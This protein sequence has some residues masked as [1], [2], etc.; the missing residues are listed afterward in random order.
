MLEREEFLAISEV[1]FSIDCGG[2]PAR[3]AELGN[4]G[5]FVADA[6]RRVRTQKTE[7]AHPL[8]ITAS[9]EPSTRGGA[10]RC[11]RVKVGKNTAFMGHTIKIGCSVRRCSEW[12][13]VGIT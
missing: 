11:R 12:A 3:F 7:N 13:D 5:F 4:C 6:D 8:W 1:P 2:V 9:H 10:K